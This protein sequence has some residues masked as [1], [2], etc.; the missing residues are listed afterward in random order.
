MGVGSQTARAFVTNR[1][2]TPTLA[3]PFIDHLEHL[4]AATGR[5]PVVALASTVASEGEARF[6]LNAIGMVSQMSTAQEPV[7]AID[8]VGRILVART[9]GGHLEVPAP[10]D[11]IAWTET[12]KSFAA[13]KNLKGTPRTIVVTGLASDRARQG[14]QA[15]RWNVH[16]HSKR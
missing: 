15:T 1:W 3:V 8:L 10:V 5:V 16:E 11:Y 12:V 7:T 2:L 4:A 14:L 13:Q 6:M 9:R